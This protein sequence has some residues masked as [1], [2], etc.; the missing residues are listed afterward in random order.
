MNRRHLV[1]GVQAASSPFSA[2]LL[3]DFLAPG[4]T[5]L[6]QV[7]DR[8]LHI[9]RL[10]R[11]QRC[12][13]PTVQVPPCI[14]GT[15]LG[16]KLADRMLPS[17]WLLITAEDVPQ[18]R[19]GWV[20]VEPSARIKHERDLGLREAKT[21]SCAFCQKAAASKKCTICWLTYYCDKDCQQRHWKQHKSHCVAPAW[22]AQE[23]YAI[24]VP[25]Y[26]CFLQYK[27]HCQRAGS[28][29][30]GGPDIC[31]LGES[32]FL[33]R[34]GEAQLLRTCLTLAYAGKPAMTCMTVIRTP[35][36]QSQLSPARLS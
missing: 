30:H 10:A 28:H 15:V 13:R 1:H 17:D 6:T 31:V 36:R 27:V 32:T 16:K 22:Q 12:Q 8:Q 20:P 35:T 14:A 2:D 26:A 25:D 23:E 5:P 11:R 19:S 34:F 7:T 21:D 29:E 33:K 24:A 18:C 3:C 9:I 4:C